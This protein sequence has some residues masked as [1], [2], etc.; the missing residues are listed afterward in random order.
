MKKII[1]SFLIILSSFSISN[2]TYAE[3]TSTSNAMFKLYK[4][5]I[6]TRSQIKKDYKDWDKIN[7]KIE[8]FFINLHF[9]SDRIKRLKEIEKK[10]VKLD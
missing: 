5:A 10:D 2:F 3:T 8:K 9:K 4:K 6:L 1:I 7:K